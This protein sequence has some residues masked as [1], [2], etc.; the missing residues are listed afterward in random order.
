MKQKKLI[1]TFPDDYSLY[2]SES[3]PEKYYAIQDR[4]IDRM[5]RV[6][7]QYNIDPVPDKETVEAF[8]IGKVAE[9]NNGVGVWD[10][11]DKKP[12]NLRINDLSSVGIELKS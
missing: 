7:L 6:K 5:F 9:D 10:F 8:R 12:V 2:N 3:E 1:K 4:E 11:T